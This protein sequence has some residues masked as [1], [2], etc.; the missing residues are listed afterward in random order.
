MKTKT[1]TWISLILFCACTAGAEDLVNKKM[2]NGSFEQGSYG[3][4]V[5]AFGSYD[6]ER[7]LMEADKDSPAPEGKHYLKISAS[8]GHDEPLAVRA[9]KRLEKESFRKGRKVNVSA[10][11]RTRSLEEFS[12]AYII[13]V[14]YHEDKSVKPLIHVGDLLQLK[15]TDWTELTHEFTLESDVTAEPLEVR[16]CFRTIGNI[17]AGKQ[18][19]GYVDDLNVTV[20]K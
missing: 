19:V 18:A 7:E 13:V 15:N 9:T 1:L 17:G 16:V 14:F 11:V 20:G 6:A 3:W 2:N 5:H 8:S 10:K 4:L 12:R